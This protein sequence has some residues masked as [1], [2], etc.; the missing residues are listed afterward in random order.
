MIEPYKNP[1]DISACL[2]SIVTLIRPII[3]VVRV[4]FGD[5]LQMNV[6]IIGNCN[7][8]FSRRSKMAGPYPQNP[9]PS[10]RVH[11]FISKKFFK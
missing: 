6:F 1:Y 7:A 10:P 9:I 5:W 11:C 4:N 8:A 2:P 3:G